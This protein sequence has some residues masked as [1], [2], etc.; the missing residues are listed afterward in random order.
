MGDEVSKVST[1]SRLTKTTRKSASAEAFENCPP[2]VTLISPQ[3]RLQSAKTGII[4]Y[5]HRT[6]L[7]CEQAASLSPSYLCSFTRKNLKCRRFLHC[8][9][10]FDCNRALNFSK[11]YQKSSKR[12]RFRLV[13]DKKQLTLIFTRIT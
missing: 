6:L 12:Q 13:S 8:F 11:R 4:V 2:C 5:R 1:K 10:N 3:C 9:R 7:V